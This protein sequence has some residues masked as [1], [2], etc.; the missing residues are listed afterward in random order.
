MDNQKTNLNYEKVL[1]D[2]VPNCLTKIKQA[3]GLDSF[4][5]QLSKPFAL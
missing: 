5:T 2:I 1:A 4:S 3:W